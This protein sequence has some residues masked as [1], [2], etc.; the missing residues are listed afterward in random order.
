MT[1]SLVATGAYLRALPE[2]HARVW[3]RAA[4]DVAWVLR[5]LR[6]QGVGASSILVVVAGP[7]SPA[8]PLL[9]ETLPGW[10]VAGPCPASP[11]TPVTAVIVG[12]AMREFV[13]AVEDAASYMAELP[14]GCCGLLVMGSDGPV[15]S[16][17]EM[18]TACPLGRDAHLSSG[19]RRR[20]RRAIS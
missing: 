10:I 1:A 19:H 17:C 20:N 7:R 18:P 4:P 6:R 8:G 2:D 16:A 12:R 15:I 3:R 9:E 11:S 5:E 14:A 13:G